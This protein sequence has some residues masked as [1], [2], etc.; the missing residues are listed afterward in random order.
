MVQKS[1]KNKKM[2]N[3]NKNQII[4]KFALSTFAVKNRTT[5]LLLTLLILVTG[6]GAYQAMPKENFPEISIPTIYVGMTYPGNSPLDMENLITRHI[7]K[8]IN[9]ITGVS[10]IKSSIIQDYST[11]I[12]EF[13]FSTDVSEALMDVKDAVD[14]VRGD[15]PS[16]MDI[17]PNIFEM[18]FSAVPVININVYGERYTLDQLNDYAEIL[19]DRIEALPQISK[20]E[21]RGSVQK[22]VKIEVDKQKM[23]GLE[24]SFRDIENAIGRENK[25]ISAGDLLVNE[26]RRS[27]RIVGEFQEPKNPLDKS[28]EEQIENIIIK[29]Q[30]QMTVK[31]RDIAKV[32]FEAKEPDSYARIF[33]KPVV[34]LDIMKRSGENLLDAV[35][36]IKEIVKNTQKELPSDVNISITN[37]TSKKTELMLSNLQNSII[38]G[39]ILVV[40]ILLFFLGLRNALFVGVAIPMS[41]VMSFVILSMMGITLNMMV[42][43]SLV[44][45]LGMLV[46]N[47]IVVVENIY[48]L[49]E[50][51]KNKVDASIEGVGE[52]AV[53]IIASTATTLAAFVPLIFWDGIMGEFMKYLPITL[54]IVLSSSLFVAL[55]INPVLTSYL[56]KV[57]DLTAKFKMPKK[58]F[59]III[60]LLILIFVPVSYI[61]FT[62]G[63]SNLVLLANFILLIVGIV[64]LNVFLFEPLS[65]FFQTKV[66]VILE[67]FYAKSIRWALKKY[68]PIILSVAMVVLFVLTMV[69]F[70][71]NTPPVEFFPET[72]PAYVNVLIDFPTGTDIE[73]TNKIVKQAE[74]RLFNGLKDYGFGGKDGHIEAILTNI[75]T[76]TVDPNS[77]RAGEDQGVKP[78]QA[79]ITVSFVE[80]EDRT[81]GPKKPLNSFEALKEI[82]DLVGEIPGATVSVGRNPEGPPTGPPINIAI[83]GERYDVLAEIQDQVRTLIN[84]SGI[85]GIDALKTDLDEGKPEMIITVNRDAA[86]TLGV[87]TSQIAGDL[88]TALFGKEVSKYKQGDND[89]PIML[90]LKDSQRYNLETLKNVIITYRDQSTGKIKQIP[91]AAVAN[92]EYSNAI[93]KV[94]R[95]NLDRV[96]TLYSNLVKGY[97]ANEIVAELKPLIKEKIDLP[98]GYN[99][100]FTGEQE[101]QAKSMAFLGNAMMIAVFVIFLIIV[102]QFNSITAP[103]IIMLSVFLST[104]GVFIGISIFGDSFVVIMTMIGIISLAGVVV[105]NAIV[106]IDFIFLTR[107]RLMLEKGLTNAN[108]LPRHLITEAIIDAGKTRL[109][110]VLLT[111]ITTVLGL[112]P[113]AIGFNVNFMTLLSDFDPQF[114][115]GGDNKAFWG[116][117]S[118]TVIYGLTFATFL[119]LVIIPVMI[120]LVDRVS[121]RF[122]K[123]L[124][125]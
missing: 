29:N 49:V 17:E 111:A 64:L 67:N 83:S 81:K 56:I 121:F 40:L 39:V 50:E 86:R 106:L 25:T 103:V 21:V 116:P 107:D 2:E 124:G 3:N 12:V 104:I 35:A 41:M 30:Y 27:I 16:D 19:E 26:H 28:I 51:G 97:N 62:K 53:P 123:F 105:N 10:K 82:K 55:V 61:N 22:E 20:V 58:W 69:Y 60:V 85:K 78:N 99:I 117:L 15:L 66:L 110:P 43:F 109:R 89:F 1:L 79:K 101:E 44:L 100:S 125:K 113:L 38:S 36:E 72:S 102:T 68:N 119:T 4:R 18:D 14:K 75:G 70:A 93:G 118:W 115:M 77:G 80:F 114:Y 120:L 46:D 34:S 91:V 112:I 24:I 92:I 52:V 9:T 54:I 45:A 13:D 73:K 94:R 6:I 5:I 48:R 90:R 87:S 32:K 63:A 74:Q 76:G 11:T 47:G 98:D 8:E 57:Q 23:E 31:L 37:D 122:G 96:V 59:W 88:R 33:G 71:K 84:N 7:E 95:V 108:D 65:K 42:L